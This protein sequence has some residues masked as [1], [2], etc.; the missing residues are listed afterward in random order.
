MF[1]YIQIFIVFLFIHKKSNEERFH[2]NF[3]PEFDAV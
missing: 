1:Q 3:R 2:F